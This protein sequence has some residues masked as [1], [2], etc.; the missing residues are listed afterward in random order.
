MKV[1]EIIKAGKVL[2]ITAS[3]RPW[4]DDGDGLVSKGDSLLGLDINDTPQI[5]RESDRKFIIHAVNNY[6]ILVAEIEKLRKTAK[7]MEEN[8]TFIGNGKNIPAG[9]G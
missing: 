7:Y 1:D 6:H 4:V 2:E 3:E 8:F 5:W 9:E